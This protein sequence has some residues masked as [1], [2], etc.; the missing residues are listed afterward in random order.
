MTRNT[1]VGNVTVED[2]LRAGGVDVSSLQRAIEEILA[3]VDILIAIRV[4]S[5]MSAEMARQL[6][7]VRM[8]VV[9]EPKTP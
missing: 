2:V 7:G 5:A 3:D 4:L 1:I 9:I 8:K 6:H